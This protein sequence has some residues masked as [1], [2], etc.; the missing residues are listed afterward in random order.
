M[1]LKEIKEQNKE[2]SIE[3]FLLMS[4]KAKDIE[5][6][7]KRLAKAVSESNGIVGSTIKINKVSD[8][9]KLPQLMLQVQEPIDRED[10]E[11]EE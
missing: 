11:E 3:V 1:N 2:V 10:N 6:L 8:I 7:C 4:P 9:E 5:R